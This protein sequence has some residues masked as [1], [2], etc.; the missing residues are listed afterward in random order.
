MAQRLALAS[1]LSGYLT[2]HNSGDAYNVVSDNLPIV[3]VNDDDSLL[4]EWAS[5]MYGAPADAAPECAFFNFSIRYDANL[6]NHFVL[7][8]ASAMPRQALHR[9]LRCAA[10]HET[11]CILSPEIGLAVPAAF[12]FDARGEVQTVLGPRL[13]PLQDAEQQHVRLAPPD[14]DGLTDTLTVEFYKTVRAE[15]LDGESKALRTRVFSGNDAYCVQL[16]RFA[17]EPKCWKQLD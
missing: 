7:G 3:K 5:E 12:V 16:L 15:F 4:K 10:Q 17:F 11:E 8:R 1:I 9:A 6:C 13:L 14:G 2:W